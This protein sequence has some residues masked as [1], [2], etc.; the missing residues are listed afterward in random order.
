MESLDASDFSDIEAMLEKDDKPLDAAADHYGAMD[1]DLDLDISHGVETDTAVSSQWGQDE[2]VALAEVNDEAPDGIDPTPSRA[3]ALN[4]L[5]QDGHRSGGLRIFFTLL[6]V[7]VLLFAILGGGYALRDKI[8]DRTGIAIPTI[9][10]VETV[11][12]KV[13]T[14]GIPAVSDWVRPEVKDIEGHLK[15]VTQ[16]V[17]GRF[18]TSPILGDLFVI[19][20]KVRNNYSMTRHSIRLMGRLFNKEKREV[21]EKEFFAGNTMSD[22]ELATLPMVQVD[23]RL[24]APLGDGNINARVRPGQLVSFM[25]VYANLPDDLTEFAVEVKESK[26]GVAIQ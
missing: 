15:L 9:T 26:E 5:T 17:A 2:T 12:E 19:T 16:D 24:R 4:S 11:R 3:T 13:A 20:G 21:Q 14:L 6:M 10:L 25:V 23:E 8:R 18:V 7:L 1:L 22:E